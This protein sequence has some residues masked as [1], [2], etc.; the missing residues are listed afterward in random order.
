MTIKMHFTL[1]KRPSPGCIDGTGLYCR[2]VHEKGP[3][4]GLSPLSPPPSHHLILYIPK[5]TMHIIT[6][7][8][9]I[10]LISY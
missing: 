9:I 6:I 1:V 8:I 5:Y 3:D 7:V 2:I 10:L 4:P